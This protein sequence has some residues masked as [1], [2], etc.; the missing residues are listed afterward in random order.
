MRIVILQLHGVSSSPVLRFEETHV[1]GE[2]EVAADELA[3]HLVACYAMTRQDLIGGIDG[4]RPR[5]LFAASTLPTARL[6]YPSIAVS[7]HR[8]VIYASTLR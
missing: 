4:V 3:V 2:Y 6:P 8:A 5:R 1:S 7:S